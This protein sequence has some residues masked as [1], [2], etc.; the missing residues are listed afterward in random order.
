MANERSTPRRL[1]FSNV[2][3]STI[4]QTIAIDVVFPYMVYQLFAARLAGPAALLLVALFPLSHMIWQYNQQ[5][6]LDLIALA[7]LYVIFWVML[8]A[9]LPDVSP[10][11]ATILHYVLPIAIL[12]LLT[13]LTRWMRMPLLFY[14]DRYCHAHTP[15]H[16]ADYTDYWQE[17]AEYRQLIFRMNNVWG[18]DNF[19]FRS[20]CYC[21]SC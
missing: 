7:A 1:N 10:L 9:L 3:P 5:R 11:L 18:W 19:S 17:S 16:I 14:I 12:G 13:L 6:S 21:S 8:G 15:D 2:I 4:L 20:L